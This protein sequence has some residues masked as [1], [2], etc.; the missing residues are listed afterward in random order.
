MFAAVLRT[1]SGPRAGPLATLVSLVL[2]LALVATWMSARR[3]E[4]AL[5]A[6]VADLTRQVRESGAHWQARL[7]SCERRGGPAQ[8]RP[9]Q[10]ADGGAAANRAALAQQ[11]A[12]QPP[13]GFDVCAR[14][15]SADQA[16]LSTLR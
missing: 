8:A 6:R 9:I 1:L 16:V 13:E 5:E 15:E 4:A 14:M 12:A 11:L 2:A 7:A 3:T 10:V